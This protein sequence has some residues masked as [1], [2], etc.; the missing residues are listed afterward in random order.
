MNK[1]ILRLILELY[2]AIVVSFLIY[3]PIVL[4]II[5]SFNEGIYFT[6]P[7]KNLTVKWYLE[8]FK[9]TSFFQ[10]IM[11]SIYV[12]SISTV[13][14]IL[15]GT[16]AAFSFMSFKNNSA[17]VG[18]VFLP[19]IVPW[20]IIGVSLLVFFSLLNVQLSLLTVA[21][22]HVVYSIP[23]VV[24]IVSTRLLTL[25][26]NLERASL[27]LGADR[28]YTFRNVTLPLIYPAISV[29]G[30]IVFLWSFD[31]FI[32]TFFTIG[33]D[34]TFPLWMWSA[35]R[36]PANIPI[37]TA[38]SSLIILVGFVIVY[39]VESYRIKKGLFTSSIF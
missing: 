30:L 21:I 24:L 4:V 36:R 35:I 20:L 38:A 33:T 10:A 6:F 34:E 22:G 13:I 8:L 18:F 5:F 32:I 16:P 14:S 2:T 39:F 1:D 15:V 17:F 25:N 7:L 29:A 37:I 3:L 26:P 27:V 19:F 12:A 23:L 31:N 28:I 11:N 9:D